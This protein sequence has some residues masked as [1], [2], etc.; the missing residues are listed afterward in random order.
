MSNLL[1]PYDTLADL[2]CM[3]DPRPPLFIPLNAEHYDAFKN[4]TKRRGPSGFMEEYR[5]AGGR[6]N[7][8]TCSPGRCVTLSRGYGKANRM[9]GRIIEF[10]EAEYEATLP[11]FVEIYG[12]GHRAAC[13]AIEVHP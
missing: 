13:I 4:G 12:L 10:R 3:D 9:E 7:S 5:L 6:W 1:P 11:A 2:A 8:R